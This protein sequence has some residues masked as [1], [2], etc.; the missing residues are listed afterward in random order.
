MRKLLTLSLL[1]LCSHSLFAADASGGRWRL[2]ILAAE[3]STTGSN[4]FAG[5]EAWSDDAHAGVG[6]GLAYVFSPRWDV[7]LTAASQT[8]QSPFTNL[9]YTA[10]PNGQP[11]IFAPSTEF[12]EYRVHPV[13]LSVTRHFLSD[14]PIAPYVRA[15]VRYVGAPNDPGTVSVVAPI[16]SRQ[17]L[18]FSPV[19]AGFGVG[20]S[21]SAQA[22]AGVRVRMTQR[23]A[24]RA[25][26]TRLLRSEEGSDPLLRYA[27]GLSFGF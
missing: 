27:V 12:R 10:M 26:A 24:F 6:L 11:G 5:N 21:L 4:S 18:P 19:R 23:M 8:H 22:G 7:E 16:P 13:D 25:E 2:S 17:T 15:G 1:L 9:V 14:G 20:D 3:I